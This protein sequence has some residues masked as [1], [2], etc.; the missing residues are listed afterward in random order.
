[1]SKS[2]KLKDLKKLQPKTKRLLICAFFATIIV[3]ILTAGLTGQIDEV[4]KLIIILF[5]KGK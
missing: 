3:F 5:G 1:M 2:K 4:V